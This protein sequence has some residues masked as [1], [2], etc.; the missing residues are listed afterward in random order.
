MSGY[1]YRR[2][3]SKH[4]YN[5]RQ[6]KK[7]CRISDILARISQIPFLRNR[8]S[9]Y[10]GTALNFIHFPQPQRLSVDIDFNYRHIDKDRDWGDVRDQIDASIKQIL[11]GQG[12]KD[13]DIKIEATYPLC[14]F[15]VDY[16]NHL[17]HR[18]GFKIETGYMRRM[19][20]LSKDALMDFRHIGADTHHTIKTPQAEEIYANKWITLLARATPRDLY[21]VHVI[22]KARADKS[23]L[24]KCGVIESLMSLDRPLTSVDPEKTINSI[25]YDE[26][27]RAVISTH[28]SP[29][30]DTI[31]SEA[32]HYS[33]SII[34]NLTKDEK[35]CIN[36]FHTQKKFQPELL[37][38]EEINPEIRS[39]PTIKWV[40]Q[41]Q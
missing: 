14:R 13:V 17:A 19:P 27:L 30:I 31:R 6:L 25:N 24:R 8:L 28:Q 7:L 29:D 36:L 32:I 15:N 4:P 10:G 21:D 11:Y 9:L 12:Y 23:T 34:N 1:D 2:L 3:Q 16:I 5:P 26:S 38:L 40:Q 20:I 39:H 37:G 33:E 41:Q 18:D 22:T 35:R